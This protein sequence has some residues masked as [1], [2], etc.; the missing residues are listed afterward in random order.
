MYAW[1]AEP[2]CDSCA[3]AIIRNLDPKNDDGTTEN[4]PQWF[5]AGETDCPQHCGSGEECLEAITLPSGRKIGALLGDELTDD[6]EAY[7]LDAR[8]GEVVDLWM[9]HFAINPPEE[10]E[11]EEEGD[12][13]E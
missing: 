9:Q 2:W 10:E 6:G 4:Y 7:V 1:K 5:P 12:E 11:D 8:P 3:E 13:D